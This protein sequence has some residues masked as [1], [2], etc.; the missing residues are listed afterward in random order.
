MEQLLRSTVY[1]VFADEDGVPFEGV[2]TDVF[3]AGVFIRP[4]QENE[5]IATV[6]FYPWTSIWRLEIL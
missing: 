3:P 6:S 4:V 5:E 1:V 2:V